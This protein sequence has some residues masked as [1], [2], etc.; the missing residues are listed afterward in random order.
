MKRAVNRTFSILRLIA[1]CLV[2]SAFLLSC[3]SVVP[4]STYPDDLD[5]ISGDQW[6]SDLAYLREQL[7]ERHPNPFHEGREAEFDAIFDSLAASARGAPASAGLA[8]SVVAGAAKMLA[9]V[10]E[11]HTSIN[12][13][14][15]SY[16]PLVARWFGSGAERELRVVRVQEA[17]R[18]SLGCQVTAVNGQPLA[19]VVA[20]LDSCV[21]ADHSN[22]YA[23]SE[24]SV[25]VNPRVMRGLGL[26]DSSGVTYSLQPDVGL[27]WD[28][29][30]PEVPAADLELVDIWEGTSANRALS[31]Q[32]TGEGRWYDVLG[33]T[34]YIA[35]DSCDSDAYGF[36]QGIVNELRDGR[37]DRVVLDL[38]RNGGGDSAPGTWFARAVAGIPSVNRAGGLYLLV[39]P[40]TFSSAMML[41]ADFMDR[42]EARFA[43]EQLAERVDSWGEVERFSLPN[44]GLV[45]G[46]STKYFTYSRGKTLRTMDG[47]I[48]PDTG[49]DRT[50]TYAEWAA[51]RDPLLECVMQKGTP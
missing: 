39:G 7:L 17:Y 23:S 37:V 42:T 25:L 38:R 49:L 3:A 4:W 11:G 27:G 20:L 47:V 46:H 15:S 40:Q 48:V 45:I 6:V 16:F 18:D 19:A 50:P 32:H 22:A 12:A 36:F 13:S 51:G 43:G 5:A 26:A 34:M 28:L 41:A 9:T 30:V 14:P 1:V 44:S 33:T 2:V 8:D 31:Y 24:P 35:Y 29:T 10:G 21:S